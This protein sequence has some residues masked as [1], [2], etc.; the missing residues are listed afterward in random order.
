M[1]PTD[2]AE[3]AGDSVEVLFRWYAKCLDGRRER[4]NR[5][6]TCALHDGDEDHSNGAGEA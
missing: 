1:D 5:L 6:I 2:V 3:R 4:N